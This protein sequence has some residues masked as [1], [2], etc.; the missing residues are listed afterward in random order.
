[1]R[2]LLQ[3]QL[4]TLEE[5]TLRGHQ[6]S[7][8]PI[9]AT[10]GV[11]GLPQSATGQTTLLTGINAAEVLGYHYGPYPNDSLRQILKRES[12]LKRL[13]QNGCA[14]F[15]ANAFP[16]IYLERLT[17]G[18]GRSTTISL[19]FQLAGVPLNGEKELREGRA[20]SAYLTQEHWRLFGYDLPLIS[21]HE[22]GERLYRLSRE[23]DFTI[24][25]YFRSDICGH[26]GHRAQALAAIEEIDEFLG[27]V[28]ANFEPHDH[29][30]IVTSDHGNLED[31]SVRGHTHN[32][33]P[34]LFVGKGHET[35]ASRVAH[36][37]DMAPALL[38]VLS[39]SREKTNDP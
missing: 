36:L 20:L 5:R 35:L 23:Y 4:P 11:P 21:P 22:A 17:R 19:A 29:L 37:Y 10:L 33:V 8:V 18:T 26:K 2:T 30:L 27:G 16:P 12:I 34:G 13:L 14:V 38:G 9:D 28:L 1:M 24:F 6:A 31:W 15:Y 7:L 3:G 25:D 32:P 39:L